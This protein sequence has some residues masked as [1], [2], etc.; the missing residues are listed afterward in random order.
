[1]SIAGQGFTRPAQG[2]V[3]AGTPHAAQAGAAILRAGGNAADAAVA[4]ALALAVSDP[5]NCSFFGRCQMLWRDVEG[6]TTAVDGATAV[7]RA[8]TTPG[9]A[10]YA[11][12]GIP[13]L[14]QALARLHALHGVLPLPVVADPAI[15]LAEDGFAPTAQLG[16]VWA[17][18]LPALALDPAAAIYAGDG[19]QVPSPFRHP[20]L[21]ALLRDFASLG[22]RALTDPQRAA[23]L[24]DGVRG[25]GGHWQ[26]VDIIANAARS[27]EVLTVRFRD[28]EVTTIGRQGWGHSLVQ[29]LAILDLLPRFGRT[30]SAR[31]ARLLVLVIRHVL[32]D[33]P[34]QLGTLE[35]RADGIALA[36]LASAAHAR[37][38]VEEIRAELDAL[39]EPI[40]LDAETLKAPA[41]TS[42][43]DTTHASV[44]DKDGNCVT[45]T[46]SIGPHFGQRVA[47]PLHGV[48]LA[49]SYQIERQPTPGARDV[50]EMCPAI[51][52]RDGQLVAALGAAG[53]ERIPGAVMQVIV[54]LID[55]GLSLDEAVRF[56]RVTIRGRIPRVHAHA[57]PKVIGSLAAWGTRPELAGEGHVNHLGVVHAVGMTPAGTAVGSADP[58]WDGAAVS[59]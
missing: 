15:R 45:F 46:C 43:Q 21:A 38:R 34:Q 55:R 47:D 54:N 16:R 49:R 13:G 8:A 58:A 56:P 7:P 1:M 57:G 29:M 11:G 39:P 17:A 35:P 4:T 6:R 48:L 10:G 44:L 42:D 19:R 20:R 28:C 51:V 36:R 41:V 23:A 32:G 2:M 22:A 3:C 25:C 30:M 53:S 27:G 50:T 24:A 18:Q 40:P 5:A 59:G 26:A 12:A 52:T 33:R 9:A 31:E 37:R 14:P